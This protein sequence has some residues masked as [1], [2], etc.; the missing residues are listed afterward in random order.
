MSIVSG[1]QQSFDAEVLS[2]E[3]QGA[4]LKHCTLTSLNKVCY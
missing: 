4:M 1:E 3:K 2:V